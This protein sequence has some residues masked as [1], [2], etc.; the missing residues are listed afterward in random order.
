[1]SPGLKN[2]VTTAIGEE[3][4]PVKNITTSPG[5]RVVAPTL[6]H[7]LELPLN[8]PGKPLPELTAVEETEVATVSTS[9]KAEVPEIKEEVHV[10]TIEPTKSLQETEEVPVTQPSEINEVSVETEVDSTSK[11][12][13]EVQPMEEDV[14][15]KDES[16]NEESTVPVVTEE[17]EITVDQRNT[18]DSTVKEENVE[19]SVAF[20]NEVEVSQSEENVTKV[21]ETTVEEPPSLKLE[22]AEEEETVVEKEEKMAEERVEESSD[23]KVEDQKP[24]EIE[25]IS[26]T[27]AETPKGG[28]RPQ[29]GMRKKNVNRE[30]DGATDEKSKSAEQGP[31]TR[32]SSGR[33]GT[34]SD[35]PETDITEEPSEAN[36]P[37]SV[38]KKRTS[39][40]PPLYVPISSPAPSSGIDSTPN[41]PTSSVST[42]A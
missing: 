36:L 5:T 41:S 2:L 20:E 10:A 42:V 3:S 27:E 17:E 15:D 32:R 18:S 8:S 25:N 19:V 13:E 34:Q 30:L 7:L 4:S 37:A 40:P 38:G 31:T 6:T 11:P 22:P 21:E 12:P 28:R 26:K 16:K 33:K 24:N 23:E 9:D 35:E 39:L 29:R 1:M 14:L